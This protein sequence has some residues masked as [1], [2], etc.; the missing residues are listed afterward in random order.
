MVGPVSNY[1]FFF[2]KRMYQCTNEKNSILEIAGKIR[3]FRTIRTDRTDRYVCMSILANYVR[4]NFVHRP[5]MSDA[6]C[7]QAHYV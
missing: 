3:V 2:L 5:I 6:L 7:L 1:L 4:I